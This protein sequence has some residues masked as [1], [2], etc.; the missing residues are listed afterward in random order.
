MLSSVYN[1][2][3]IQDQIIEQILERQT[4]SN[5]VRDQDIAADLELDLPTLRVHLELLACD[6]R[7]ELIRG[8]TEY[9]ACVLDRQRPPASLMQPRQDDSQSA[10]ACQNGSLAP[11][12]NSSL[13]PQ[14]LMRQRWE[15][16]GERLDAI[17]DVI[18]RIAAW[19]PLTLGAGGAVLG[20]FSTGPAMRTETSFYVGVF[21]LLIGLMLRKELD[22]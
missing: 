19:A 22:R 21:G 17:R 7:L 20:W 10:F 1:P 4:E 12:Y 11:R 16:T 18:H 14:E 2:L 5:P 8:E 9:H 13:S 15:R 6:D 3:E